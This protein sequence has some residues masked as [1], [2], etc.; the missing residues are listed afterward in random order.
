MKNK[1]L[2]LVTISGRSDPDALSLL[3]DFYNAV[4]LRDTLATLLKISLDVSQ[5][6]NRKVL[7]KPNW[8]KHSSTAQDEVCLRTNDSF[9]IAVL[10]AVLE[11]K[12]LEV[13]IGD[14]PIQGCNWDKMITRKFKEEINNLS[15]KYD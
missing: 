13:V 10:I 14:A 1:F 11:M 3:S 6:T 7:L 2:N 5:I 4:G 9:T 12:P 8:V 15:H